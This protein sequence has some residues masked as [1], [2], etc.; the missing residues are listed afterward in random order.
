MRAGYKEPE[1]LAGQ[2]DL[3][4]HWPKNSN[5]STPAPPIPYVRA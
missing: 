1:L 3:E 2:G 5:A 4:A